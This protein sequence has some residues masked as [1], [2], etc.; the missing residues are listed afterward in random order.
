MHLSP[1]AIL[2]FV[3]CRLRSKIPAD[4]LLVLETLPR[5]NE[6][7]HFDKDTQLRVIDRYCV[8][9]NWC[10]WRNIPSGCKS[11]RRPR[12][13]YS[14]QD[15]D[16]SFHTFKSQ[17]RVIS[18]LFKIICSFLSTNKIHKGPILL[19]FLVWASLTASRVAVPQAVVLKLLVGRQ[20]LQP[21]VCG[22]LLKLM[23]S[24]ASR[25]LGQFFFVFFYSGNLCETV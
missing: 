18:C 22:L 21:S 1:F 8:I 4:A 16:A 12:G 13:F 2:G 10:D 3:C 17:L 11:S 14:F 5:K 9:V 20:H 25:V 7:M 6:L 15:L 24:W 23:I 19:P